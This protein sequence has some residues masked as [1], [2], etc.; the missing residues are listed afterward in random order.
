M[1]AFAPLAASN[2]KNSDVNSLWASDDDDDAS[3][4]ASRRSIRSKARSCVYC[5]FSIP[6]AQYIKLLVL[7]VLA[8]IHLV[9]LGDN[10]DKARAFLKLTHE[11]ELPH[12]YDNR[13][14]DIFLPQ[15]L[16]AKEYVIEYQR[17]LW[18]AVGS[19]CTA[20]CIST[21]ILMDMFEYTNN[22]RNIATLFRVI[23]VLSIL[24]IALTLLFRLDAASHIAPSLPAG[25]RAANHLVSSNEFV[26]ALNCTILPRDNELSLCADVFMS[27]LFP[28]KLLQYLIILLVLTGAYVA[29][30][31]LIEWCIRHYFPPKYE[32]SPI[33]AVSR[34]MLIADIKSI[35]SAEQHVL[36]HA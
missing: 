14:A 21:I 6:T 22:T 31:Y 32:P 28:I 17:S 25:L 15:L 36:I 24:F 2:E 20:L 18:L 26:N 5:I 19:M 4:I 9:Y 13:Q 7:F 1:P 10:L 30:A 35:L 16:I 12:R 27:S 33:S 11:A 34:D 8:I 3:S 23:D 29:L